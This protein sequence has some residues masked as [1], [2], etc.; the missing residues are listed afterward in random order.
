MKSCAFF[1]LYACT[2]V[3]AAASSPELPFTIVENRGQMQ[4]AARFVGQGP[5]FRAEFEDQ[6]VLLEDGGGITRIDFP[7]VNPG[8][9]VAAEQESGATINYLMGTDSSRWKTNLPAF[10][11]ARYANV[12]P[13][14]D[15][16]F[17]AD[18]SH[19][20]A[21]FHLGAGSSAASIRLHFDGVPV[22]TP[23]GGLLIQTSAGEVSLPA[24]EVIAESGALAEPA[25]ASYMVRGGNTVSLA[26]ASG[27]AARLSA[28]SKN[29][30]LLFSGY[31][32]GSSQDNIT[33]VAITTSFN[34]VV[35]GWT[36][37]PD[38][39]ATGARRTSGGGVDAFVANFSPVGG[40]LVYCTYLGG[41]GDDRA[42]GIAVDQ[43]QNTYIT[44]WTS[45][46]NFP[47]V[48]G[49]QSRLS[50]ARDA[51]VTKLNPTGTAII[52]STYLG[53]TGIDSAAAIALDAT[54]AVV[55]VGDTTSTNLP[56]TAGAYQRHLAG[57][58]DVF[59]ARLNP[60]G[61]AISMLTWLGGSASEHGAAVKID[62]SGNII[63]GGGTYSIDF[64]TTAGLQTVS[65]GGQDGFVSKLSANG[66]AMLWSTYLGG[67]GGS[68]GAPETVTGISLSAAGNP[69]VVGITSSVDFPIRGAAPQ[70]VF[71]G[72][73]TDGFLA[74]LTG[75]NSGLLTLSTFIGG[76][77]DDGINAITKD[78]LGLMYV[79]GYTSS[80]D[81]PIRR[82]AQS[83]PGGGMDAFVAK[84]DGT[85]RIIY[86]SWLGGS[87]SDSANAVAADS[88][89]NVVV[90]GSTGSPDFPLAGAMPRY[91]PGLLSGFVTKIGA[92]W[93]TGT[94]SLPTVYRDSWRINGF[95]G[96]TPAFTL[97]SFGQAGDIPV[98]GD[99][100]GTGVNRL[101][102]F[103]NGLWILDT[104]NNGVQDASDLIVNFGQAG[105][106]PVFGFF[107]GTGR[108]QLGLFRAGT[109]VLDL[110]GHL[111]GVAT[112]TPDATFTFGQAGDIPITGDWNGSGTTKVGVFRSGV[113]KLDYNGDRAFTSA[114]PTYTFGLAGDLPVVGDWNSTGDATRIGVYRAGYWILDN[115]GNGQIDNPGVRELYFA[116]GGPTL[117]PLVW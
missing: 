22:A 111:T 54:G 104:N 12:W 9:K 14:V 99:W 61:N 35:A 101:G 50:G 27:L 105:D 8:T 3:I 56:A 90:V 26:V 18:G 114:D 47:V 72:G 7:G 84:M 71:G 58:Q 32:G 5:G 16:V 117:K 73:Q 97:N 28:V 103:R 64:P 19:A 88:M 98:V 34:I 46:G 33:A 68:P 41:S 57:G 23:D 37:S 93:S 52:Y 82:A 75:N 81:F 91:K 94:V 59:V 107:D 116:F 115:D 110:S 69:T 4:S 78:N 30:P 85:M 113:W 24:P 31:F 15:V 77:L 39:P 49:V 6:S 66:T 13:G 44:G 40:Q 1:A 25:R 36:S 42:F 10:R 29:P 67:S 2:G 106:L 53:G 83:Q 108:P 102:V 92:S 87:A 112:G 63:V 95:N 20:R 62:P 80:S 109:F 51:F 76:S 100:T 74:R 17:Y 79:V 55:I 38:L 21:A 60:A 89:T 65:G 86:S 45:S 11:S 43:A 96:T 48:G 70:P